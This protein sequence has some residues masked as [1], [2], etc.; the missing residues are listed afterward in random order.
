MLVKAYCIDQSCVA[1][2]DC[3]VRRKNH[4][5][6]KCAHSMLDG[7]HCPGNAPLTSCKRGAGLSP[8][9]YLHPLVC[10]RPFRQYGRRGSRCSGWK[11]RRALPTPIH[12]RASAFTEPEPYLVRRDLVDLSLHA[13]HT[14]QSLTQ[15]TLFQTACCDAGSGIQSSEQCSLLGNKA[16][17]GDQA[18]SGNW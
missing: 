17:A 13:L 6:I 8:C 15:S 3:I 7:M 11:A 2:I 14:S 9:V 16:S 10:R 5:S 18:H 1:Q 4:C 12:A